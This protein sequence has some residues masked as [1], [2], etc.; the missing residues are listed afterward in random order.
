MSYSS[1]SQVRVFATWQMNRLTRCTSLSIHNTSMSGSARSSNRQTSNNNNIH[2]IIPT[3]NPLATTRVLRRFFPSRKTIPARMISPIYCSQPNRQG[4]QVHPWHG[5]PQISTK[6]ASLT[7]RAS[8]HTMRMLLTLRR[9]PGVMMTLGVMIGMIKWLSIKLSRRRSHQPQLSN[10]PYRHYRPCRHPQTYLRRRQALVSTPSKRIVS[11]I[12]S[13]HK[14]E[15][16]SIQ[17]SQAGT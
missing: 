1:V 5:Q 2:S 7:L 3:N 11:R 10:R 16:A 17:W 12:A 6:M 13:V 14:A 4:N 15:I 8:W 9:T